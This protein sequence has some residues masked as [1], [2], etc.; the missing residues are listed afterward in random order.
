MFKN[1]YQQIRFFFHFKLQF[2]YLHLFV[3]HSLFLSAFPSVLFWASVP[4]PLSLSLLPGGTS[5]AWPWTLSRST[6]N[7][8]RA[9]YDM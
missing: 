6:R 2:K 8:Y 5:L 7:S 9:Y 4:Y 3:H 1:V